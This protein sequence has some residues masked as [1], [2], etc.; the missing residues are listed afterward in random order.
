[1]EETPGVRSASLARIVPLAGGRWN[2]YVTIFGYD[3]KQGERK[4]IDMNS[5]GPRFFET[6]GVPILLGRDFRAEDSPTSIADAPSGPPPP[7]GG[8]RPEEIAGP[9]VAIINES[10][11]KKYFAGRNPIGGRLTLAE[12]F[13]PEGSFEIVGVVKDVHYFGLRQATETMVYVPA[14]RQGGG[15]YSLCIRT[16]AAPEPM[17][18]LVRQKGNALDGAIPLLRARTMEQNIDNN[19]LQEKLVATLAGFFGLLALLLAAVGLYGLM[20]HAVTRR[21]RE[22]GIRMALGAGSR[23]VLWMVLRDALLLV[24]AGAVIGV[25]AAMAVTKLAASLLYGI[26]ARDPFN[27]ILATVFLAAV[28]IFASYLPARR[29]S[30]V[31]PGTALRYQ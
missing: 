7:N 9:H 26:E 15:N 17:I 1:V 2:Q 6:M 8:L 23:A 25:P 3:Y 27:A 16:T 19:I 12:R 14:W 22:I 10:L 30:R 13:I 21:T 29:A 28:A 31:D 18:E 4:V 11:A 5:V 20:A 24:A